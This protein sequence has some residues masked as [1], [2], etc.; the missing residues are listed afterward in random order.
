MS[1]EDIINRILNNASPEIKML[2]NANFAFTKCIC[3][4]IVR[5][6]DNGVEIHLSKKEMN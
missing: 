6:K 2:L 1:K 4:E 3:D 5:L